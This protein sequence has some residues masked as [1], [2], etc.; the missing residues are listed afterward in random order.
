MVSGLPGT[1][2][3]S[4]FAQLGRAHELLDRARH[5]G[6]GDPVPVLYITVPPAATA[7]WSPP[8]SPDSW[9]AAGQ[10]Q[11]AAPRLRER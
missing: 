2:K 7:A 10:G 5:P 8:S 4:A 9:A 6:V 11:G 3:T 1:G